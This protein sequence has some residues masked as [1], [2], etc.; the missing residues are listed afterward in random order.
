MVVENYFDVEANDEEKFFHEFLLKYNNFKLEV[1]IWGSLPIGLEADLARFKT[2]DHLIRKARR[3]LFKEN[4]YIVS[5]DQSADF[6]AICK[7]IDF[8]AISWG[9]CLNEEVIVFARSIGDINVSGT[10]NIPLDGIERLLVELK[11]SGIVKS[12]EVIEDEK[13]Q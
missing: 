1:I 9:I 13:V 5:S 7:K 12:F 11:K 10:N 3:I 4:I 6:I 2:K 8:N